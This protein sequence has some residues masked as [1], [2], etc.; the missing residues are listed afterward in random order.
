MPLPL[1]SAPHHTGLALFLG[2]DRTIYLYVYTVYIRYF[3]Q[4]NHHNIRSYTVCTYGSGQPN[5]FHGLDVAIHC[6]LHTMPTCCTTLPTPFTS[7]PQCLHP[8]PHC[9]HYTLST[10][11][12]TSCTT[13]STLHNSASL[14]I[15]CTPEFEDI[16]LS[17]STAHPFAS[18]TIPLIFASPYLCCKSEGVKWSRKSSI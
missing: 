14:S 13:L 16:R 11:L 2:W 8:A 12:S 3:K 6:T 9:L 15:F 7:L 10:S 4:G 5:L 17:P 18:Q 1:H